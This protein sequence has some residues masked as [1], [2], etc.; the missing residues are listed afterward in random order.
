MTDD[1][2]T[3]ENARRDDPEWHG[4]RFPSWDSDESALRAARTEA[5]ESLSETI[6]AIRCTEESAMRMLRI[7]L[8]I[9]SLSLTAASS[10][11]FTTQFVN[12]LTV[13]GFVSVVFSAVVAVVATFGSEQPTGVSEAYLREF[14]QASWS[15]REWNEWM[16]REYSE[17]LAEANEIADGDARALLYAQLCLGVGLLALISGVTV[18]ATGL[19]D[20][21]G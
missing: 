21:F 10:F 3:P 2:D 14:Q 12:G 16:L 20:S 13:L 11:Q 18:G 7:D 5:R 19:L 9:L 8:V 15:E 1:E 4:D 17:W 6:D